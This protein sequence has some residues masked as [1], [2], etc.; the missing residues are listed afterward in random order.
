[1]PDLLFGYGGI[2]SRGTW[3]MS[4]IKARRT[5]QSMLIVDDKDDIDDVGSIDAKSVCPVI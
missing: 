5:V 1:M 3:L 2:E 4:E